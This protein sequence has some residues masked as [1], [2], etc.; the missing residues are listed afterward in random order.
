MLARQC[1][2]DPR[3]DKGCYCPLSVAGIL[4]VVSVVDFL[5]LH[6]HDVCSMG[7]IG[8]DETAAR[9]KVRVN[10]CIRVS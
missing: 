2:F 3:P 5:A 9:L 4:S 10:V 7:D 1:P 6:Q 8:R